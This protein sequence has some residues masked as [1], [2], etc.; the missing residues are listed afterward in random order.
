MPALPHLPQVTPDDLAGVISRVD[1]LSLHVS[2]SDTKK[3]E[4]DA[5]AVYSRQVDG[6]ELRQLPSCVHTCVAHL[7]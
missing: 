1:L 6:T 3:E 2:V 5:T 7:I 4:L